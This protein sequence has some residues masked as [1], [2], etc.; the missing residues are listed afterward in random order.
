MSTLS[1][2]SET[3]LRLLRQLP[4][5]ERLHVVTQILPELERELPPSSLTFDFWHSADIFML[6][7]QQ[8]VQPINDFNALLGGW[9]DGESI[10]DFVEARR[11]A[12]Q[13]N[14]VKVDLE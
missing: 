11:T 3:V 9:P 2:A 8:A 6:A 14:L 13:H 5:R 7:Q 1:A 12:R 4:P 10:D